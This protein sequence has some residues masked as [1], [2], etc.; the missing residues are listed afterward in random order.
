MK[1]GD[2]KA[3]HP[4]LTPV[5]SELTHRTY[6]AGFQEEHLKDINGGAAF[7]DQYMGKLANIL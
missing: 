1:I 3:F 7:R 5:L 4:A 2:L 6:E